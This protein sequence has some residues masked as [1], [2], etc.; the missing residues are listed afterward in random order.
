MKD[1]RGDA[2]GYRLTRRSAIREWRAKGTTRETRMLGAWTIIGHVG[3]RNVKF[4]LRSRQPVGWWSRSRGH[5]SE[6]RCGSSAHIHIKWLAFMPHWLDTETLLK[7][8]DTEAC[9][10]CR[11]SDTALI[12][13]W[14]LRKYVFPR[15]LASRDLLRRRMP[16]FLLIDAGRWLCEWPKSRDV[17]PTLAI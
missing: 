11:A 14:S 3:R 5:G 17:I 13:L 8:A 12:P 10:G 6:V 4:L 16:R 15:F 9:S 1:G 7:P 2:A